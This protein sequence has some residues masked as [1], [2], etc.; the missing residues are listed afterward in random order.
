MD[1]VVVAAPPF[2]RIRESVMNYSIERFVS[3]CRECTYFTIY[4][5]ASD[6]EAHV[7]IVLSL[8][9]NRAILLVTAAAVVAV[10][11]GLLVIGKWTNS[12]GEGAVARPRALQ[13]SRRLVPLGPR[14]RFPVHPCN[15][16][17]ASPWDKYSSS[18]STA[19]A[20]LNSSRVAFLIPLHPPKFDDASRY[21]E[22]SRRAG[23]AAEI[24]TFFLLWPADV[25]TFH[26]RFPAFKGANASYTLVVKESGVWWIDNLM[27]SKGSPDMPVRKKLIGLAM[28]YDLLKAGQLPWRYRFAIIPD[29]EIVWA[30]PVQGFAQRV[31]HHWGRDKGGPLFFGNCQVNLKPTHPTR[32]TWML[33]SQNLD[34]AAYAP[35]LKRLTDRCK[36]IGVPTNTHFIDLPIYDM[37][38]IERYL[39]FLNSLSAM[40]DDET[41]RTIAGFEHPLYINWLVGIESFGRLD[42]TI[43]PPDSNQ[44]PWTTRMRYKKDGRIDDESNFPTLAKVQRAGLMWAPLHLIERGQN[45][46]SIPDKV[47]ILFHIDVQYR[48]VK[49]NEKYKAPCCKTDPLERHALAPHPPYCSAFGDQQSFERD[50]EGAGGDGAA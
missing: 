3:Y 46:R 45:C 5:A 29:S 18:N 13:K 7:H 40:C 15:V 32:H 36:E 4:D 25:Q 37:Q 10:A 35:A 39:S 1:A 19:D 33:E 44:Y 27:K 20:D 21:L 14:R 31:E 23:A 6:E 12:D 26:D 34:A 16:Q 38:S 30:R 47:D 49:G 24:D 8:E 43:E 11:L 41:N 17:S 9:M 2:R 42:S 22:S 28:F 50:F 48:F